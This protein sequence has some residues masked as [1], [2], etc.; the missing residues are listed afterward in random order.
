MLAKNLRLRSERKPSKNTIK[1]LFFFFLWF[2]TVQSNNEIVITL[3][4][5]GRC[6]QQLANNLQVPLKKDLMRRPQ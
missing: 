3:I 4:N 5:E 2:K 1:I 6:N